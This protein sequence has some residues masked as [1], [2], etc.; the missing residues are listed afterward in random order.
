MISFD[1]LTPVTLSPTL[2]YIFSRTV[3]PAKVLQTLAAGIHIF[4]PEFPPARLLKNFNSGHRERS[5]AIPER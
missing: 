1:C 3:I 4:C 5:E 2:H